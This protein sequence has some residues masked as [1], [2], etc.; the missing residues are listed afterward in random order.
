MITSLK[1]KNFKGF[2]EA[3]VPFGPLTLLVGTNASGKSNV[4]EALQFLHGCALGYTL[5]EVIDEKWGQGGTLVWRGLRGGI[6]EIAYRGN[7]SFELSLELALKGPGRL[8]PEDFE[9]TITVNLEDKSSPR[10][11]AE[12]LRQG[13][14]TV[15]DTNPDD[16]PLTQSSD[17]NHLAARFRRGGN[18]RHSGK[19]RDYL[20]MNAIL[21]QASQDNEVNKK[22]REH[23]SLVNGY[24]RTLR[25]LDL[26]PD[27]MRE[28][29]APA[30]RLL[31][32]RGQNLSSVLY[33]IC[34]NDKRKSSLLEWLSELTP[35][36]VRDFEFEEDF[37]GR[38]IA[39]LIEQDG[40]R[41]SAVSASDGTLRF[42][43]L[44]AALLSETAGGF[45]FF[46]EIDNGIHPTRLH[47][48][49]DVLEQATRY[50]GCQIV[51]T[52]HNPQILT[53]L[54]E[55]ARE[56]AVLLY[57]RE[58]A[59]EAEAL[60]IMGFDDI[61]RILKRQQ[62][63]H[64]FASGWFEDIIAFSEDDDERES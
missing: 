56:D 8:L 11:Q 50:F 64:L 3:T 43:A 37:Q 54:S 18:Q 38:I 51:A 35:M 47:V 62:L 17:L 2:R 59:P 15:F 39:Y 61:R 48:L 20:S 28:P 16:D 12:S 58:G 7:K 13:G 46:E 57:R 19:R 55:K 22:S 6:P 32:D 10:V 31:G 27:A 36:D 26:S 30:H 34:R 23:A 53:F 40:N 4:R 5:A 1:L 42:L 9:H 52:T 21:P 29:S 24:L 63:G 14:G 60:R 25:F 45:Y 33:D 49:I 44:T 41:I